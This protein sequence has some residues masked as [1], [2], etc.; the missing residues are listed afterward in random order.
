MDDGELCDNLSHFVIT[1]ADD[2][3]EMSQSALFWSDFFRCFGLTLGQDGELE[4]H[5]TDMIAKEP[6][7]RERM[8]VFWSGRVMVE[9]KSRGKTKAEKERLLKEAE[10]Q[11]LRYF[12]KLRNDVRPKYVITCDFETIIVFEMGIEKIYMKEKGRCLVKEI[13]THR[14]L[15]NFML[16]REV[17]APQEMVNRKAADLM[18]CVYT[19]LKKTGYNDKNNITKLLTRLIYCL[20]ADDTGIFNTKGAFKK[21]VYKYDHRNNTGPQLMEL[22]NALNTDE[23]IRQ[24]VDEDKQKELGDFPW[25]NGSLFADSIQPPIFNITTWKALSRAT[26]YDWS[27]VSPEIFGTLFQDVMD[28]KEKHDTGSHYT[29][30]TNIEKVIRPLFLDELWSKFLKIMNGPNDGKKDALKELQDD[31]SK[32]TFL[33]P[34]CGSGNFLILTYKKLRELEMRIILAMYPPK[35]DPKKMPTLKDITKVDVHQFYGIDNSEYAVRITETGLWI[36]DHL[37]NREL[38]ARYAK[39]RLRRIPLEKHPHIYRKD[40]LKHDWNKFLKSDECD[41]VLGNPPFSG[42]RSMLPNQKTQSTNVTKSGGMDYVAN[43]FIKAA[44]YINDN[45]KIGLVATNSITQ[46]EQVEKLWPILTDECGLA[47]NFAYKSFKWDSEGKKKAKVTVVI[48]G[49]T[50]NPTTEKRLFDENGNETNPEFISPNLIGSSK[51]LPIVKKKYKVNNGL[52]LITQG[53]RL[54]DNNHYVFSVTEHDEFVSKE[55]KAKKYMKKYSNGHDFLHGKIRYI[56]DIDGVNPKELKKMPLVLEKIKLVETFRASKSREATLELS[57]TPKKIDRLIVCKEKY[58]ATPQ[59]FSERRDYLIIGFLEPDIIPSA[60]LKISKHSDLGIAGIL[61]SKMHMTWIRKIDGQLETRISY[62][63]KMYKSFP[64][65]VSIDELTVLRPFM[66]DILDIRNKHDSTLADL[67]DPDLIPTDLKQAHNRLDKKVDKLYRKNPFK[68]EQERIEFL[69]R[70][71]EKIKNE[72]TE[73]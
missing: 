66:Q 13:P 46:G 37:M 56:L 60:K 6:A 72:N 5:L 21:W 14:D 73:K 71:Y 59:T 23:E 45:G 18:N 10:L 22:F 50:R 8:D 7:P 4:K 41:Y 47:L 33:D 16:D 67:Y 28:K 55:P 29:S 31:I 32:L 19:E 70:R 52:P 40:S 35:T 1:H 38:S 36:M 61:S 9:Q 63:N 54:L 11:A 20:F 34:A 42:S 25:V 68:S 43:W 12:R 65:P 27:G 53:S 2:S 62:S 30:A 17:V 64:I 69:L 58:F 44:R 15:F 57:K 24:E 39:K 49:L 3:D 51:P 48:L 26:E